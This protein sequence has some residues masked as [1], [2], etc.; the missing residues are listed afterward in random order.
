[1]VLSSDSEGSCPPIRPEGWLPI[2]PPLLSYRSVPPSMGVPLM[3]VGCRKIQTGQS[4][5]KGQVNSFLL[6]KKKKGVWREKKNPYSIKGLFSSRKMCHLQSV[7]FSWNRRKTPS[8]LGFPFKAL[9][10]VFC[11]PSKCIQTSDWTVTFSLLAP[12]FSQVRKGLAGFTWR[13]GGSRQRSL[14]NVGEPQPR[15]PVLS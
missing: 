6:T 14:R 5:K 15:K 2:S 1:M 7:F 10:P 8:A 12:G 3:S 4:E 9:V 11:S 13:C